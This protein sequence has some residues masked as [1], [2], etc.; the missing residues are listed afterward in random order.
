MDTKSIPESRIRGEEG[1]PEYVI[2]KVRNSRLNGHFDNTEYHLI[3]VRGGVEVRTVSVSYSWYEA[4][5]DRLDAWE[6]AS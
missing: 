1:E 3:E 5:L 4:H 2:R 6:I